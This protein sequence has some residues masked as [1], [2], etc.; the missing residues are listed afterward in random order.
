MSET[1]R[2]SLTFQFC[3][4]EAIHKLAIVVFTFALSGF[5][6]PSLILWLS[7]VRFALFL[8]QERK[9]IVLKMALGT[10]PYFH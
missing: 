5:S 9:D 1:V 7:N 3:L 10:Q 6:M 2:L 4:H 8:S